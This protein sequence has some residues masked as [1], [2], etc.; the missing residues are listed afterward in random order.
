MERNFEFVEGVVYPAGAG[1]GNLVMDGMGGEAV[2]GDL[3]CRA[4]RRKSAR[5]RQRIP[6]RTARAEVNRARRLP[7][8]HL[9]EGVFLALRKR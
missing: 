3:P 5:S 7:I 8:T 6:E 1:H 4:E 2:H 9:R